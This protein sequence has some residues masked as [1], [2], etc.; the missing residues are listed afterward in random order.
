MINLASDRAAADLQACACFEH[1]QRWSDRLAASRHRFALFARKLD[2]PLRDE[3][4][5]QVGA[6][7][8]GEGF[9]IA[10][11]GVVGDSCQ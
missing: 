9:D 8:A 1:A 3:I 10:A 6:E 2:G 4:M 5:Q 7:A 11:V